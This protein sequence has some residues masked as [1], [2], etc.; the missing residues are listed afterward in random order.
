MNASTAVEAIKSNAAT[1]RRFAAESAAAEGRMAALAHV[2]ALSEGNMSDEEFSEL[3]ANAKRIGGK[4][5]PAYLATVAALVDVIKPK[6]SRAELLAA[7]RASG[8]LVD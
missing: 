1:A 5:G 3:Y 6:K 2:A 4:F 8:G 7:V